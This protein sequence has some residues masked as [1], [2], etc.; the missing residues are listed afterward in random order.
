MAW[1][2][3]WA[4]VASE[5][6]YPIIPLF[7]VGALKAP[8]SVLGLT[9]GIAN[10]MLNFVRGWS[11]KLSDKLGRRLPFVQAGYGLT[12]ISKPITALAAGW[13]LVSL[14]RVS[15][16]F[17]KGL[18]NT[19]RD[20][21]LADAVEHADAGR[22]FGYHRAMDAAGAVLG[23]LCGV[24]LLYFLPG[25]Y[26]LI[27]AVTA[28]PGI[29]AVWLTFFLKESRKPRTATEQQ[30]FVSAPLNQKFKRVLFVSLLFG[31]ANSSDTFLLLRARDLGMPDNLVVLSYTL[32]NVVYCT[33]AYPLGNW[34]DRVGRKTIVGIGWVVYALTYFAFAFT[35]AWGV[36]PLMAL[37]GLYNGACDGTTKAWV[38]DASDESNRGTAM[39]A[40]AMG[41]G[42]AGL[43]A[44]VTAGILWDRVDHKSPFLV[45]GA[46]ALLALVG[47]LLL[48]DKRSAS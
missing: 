22:A 15:D 4:D 47:L 30:S 27:F 20:A 40:Y 17:G 25:Q 35:P 42:F 3:F 21:L 32:F 24:A 33:C 38:R 48:R 45:G 34:S 23:S 19:A 43:V 39:G 11:G 46:M 26:R 28:V 41:T 29:V 12:A 18:R 9:E 10:V 44:S 37:Y 13:P 6:V 8:A 36:W 7:L 31:L 5:M 1:I 14:A 2:S 16:R